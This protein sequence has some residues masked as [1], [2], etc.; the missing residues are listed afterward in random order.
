MPYL[1]VPD[2][3]GWRRLPVNFGLPSGKTKPI[4]IDLGDDIDPNDPR[5]RLTTDFEVYWDRIAVAELL[6]PV[7]TEHVV[8]HV[9]ISE[10]EL[11]FAGFSRLYQTVEN[12]PGLFDYQDR[13][14]YP[15]RLDTWGTVVPLTWEELEGALTGYGDVRDLLTGIDDRMVV[16][17]SGE[18]ITITFDTA[19]LQPLADGWSRTFLLHFEGWEKDGDPNVACSQTVDPLPFRGMPAYPCPGTVDIPPAEQD[20]PRSRWVERDRLERRLE[21]ILGGEMQ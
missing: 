16:F 19:G 3:D 6:D 13:L 9:E 11:G 15:W 1:E 17:G 14:P 7:E 5:L 12:G 10:S 21:A 2:G 18:E 4:V 8:Q 20:P